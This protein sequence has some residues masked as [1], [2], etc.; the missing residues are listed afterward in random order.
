MPLVLDYSL[1][2]LQKNAHPK[3]GPQVWP[4]WRL[5]SFSIVRLNVDPPSSSRRLWVYTRFGAIYL[6]ATLDRRPNFD[7]RDYHRPWLVICGRN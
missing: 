2:H 5:V 1:A 4:W 6:D 3:H 7:A